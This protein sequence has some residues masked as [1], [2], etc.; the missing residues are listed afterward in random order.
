[1]SDLST[2][3]IWW[4][5][6]SI[7]EYILRSW[8]L[9]KIGTT[10]NQRKLFLHLPKASAS[11]RFSREA[12][13]AR[14]RYPHCQ[15]LGVSEKEV[16]EMNRR[17]NGDVSL[18]VPLNEGGDF[19]EWQDRLVDEGS[20]PELLVAES[21]ESETRR[22]ALRLALTVLDDRERQIFEARRLVDPPLTLEELATKFCVS[23]ERIRQIEDR[24]LQKVRRAAHGAMS[25]RRQSL[26]THH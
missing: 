9:V 19:V 8:S 20:D 25:R 16:V 24:A 18:N 11:S 13:C 23:R 14:P 1:M 21:E 22:K 15:G 4:I 7:Q 2:Y 10:F 26:Q 12:I 5:R 17:L 6:A 3:A